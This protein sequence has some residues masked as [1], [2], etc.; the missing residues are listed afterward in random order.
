MCT[1]CTPRLS[2]K[3]RM[4]SGKGGARHQVGQVPDLLGIGLKWCS[5]RLGEGF[6]VISDGAQRSRS[7]F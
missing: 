1:T 2:M 4:N 5:Q 6:V 7:M 3:P